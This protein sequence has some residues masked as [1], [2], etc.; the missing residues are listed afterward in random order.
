MKILKWAILVIVV[1]V[2]GALVAG[3]FGLNA[4]VRRSV[5]S[6]S[7][8]SLNLPTEL[9]SA[10]LS[11]FGGKLSLANFKIGNP[12]GYSA[13]NL[14]TLGGVDLDVSYS[15][16]RQDPM[17]VKSI[18]IQSPKLVLERSGMKLNLQAA[19]DQMTPSQPAKEPT[20]LIID[21]L[22][23]T[24]AQVVIRPNIP[25]L[26]E[27]YE[28]T[29]PPITLKDIGTADGAKN[30]AAIKEVVMLLGTSMAAKAAESRNLPPELKQLLD[31]D[32]GH[33]TEALQK[34]FNTKIQEVAGDLAKR[35][36]GNVGK[37]VEDAAK[38]PQ[39][40][41]RDPGKSLQKGLEGLA[42]GSKKEE[43]K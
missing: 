39:E 24:N 42:P 35:L 6:Q 3:Y 29:I 15:Q 40:L 32:L 23:V 9:G 1:L 25:G 34:Q 12:K 4:M 22:L 18:N 11:I 41:L 17:R 7:A 30:G 14:F 37:L 28:L 38:N 26:R 31:A 16:L 5:Q 20:R 21:E 33:L 27:Q 2:V 36:P 10:D 43:G 19:M 13:D 8:K